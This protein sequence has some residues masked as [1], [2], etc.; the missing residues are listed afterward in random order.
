MLH[1]GHGVG[2]FL[3]GWICIL[4]NARGLHEDILKTTRAAAAKTKT[5]KTIEIRELFLGFLLSLLFGETA[6]HFVNRPCT[7]SNQRQRVR[8]GPNE[9][10]I[11]ATLLLCH[12]RESI[13]S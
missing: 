12:L 11:P 10:P 3:P 4:V 1:C 6:P 9:N 2:L 8:V 5:E 7:A 13:P